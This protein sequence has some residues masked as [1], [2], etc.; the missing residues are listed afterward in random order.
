MEILVWILMVFNDDLA[1]TQPVREIPFKRLERCQ[2]VSKQVKYLA[3]AYCI[4]SV[5]DKKKKKVW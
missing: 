3:R 4:P 5:I 1:Q 2:F